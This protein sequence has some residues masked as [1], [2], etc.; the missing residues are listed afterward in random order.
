MKLS[1][2][3]ELKKFCEDLDSE[4]SWREVYLLSS[5]DDL[6]ATTDDGSDFTVNNVRFI[7]LDWLDD[8]MVD[9]LGRDDWMLGFFTASCLSDVL[10]VD[11]DTIEAMQKQEEFEAI[12]KLIKN[13]GKLD[14]LQEYYASANGYGHHFNNYDGNEESIT[15]G[16]FNYL[17]FDNH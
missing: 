1:Q 8:I 7:R 16:N 15:I 9:E 5:A 13:M 14:E 2:F 3:R 12:G 6:M 4:P 10:R 17:V 11:A